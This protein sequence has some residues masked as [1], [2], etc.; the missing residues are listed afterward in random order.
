MS[1]ASFGPLPRPQPNPIPG[2]PALEAAIR[3]LEAITPTTPAD[4]T[5]ALQNTGAGGSG[6][7]G[8]SAVWQAAAALLITID[9]D[10]RYD[11]QRLF[12]RT[13][14]A[15]E[16]DLAKPLE[17]RRLVPV[18]FLVQHLGRPR[19]HP[20]NLWEQDQKGID[21]LLR[22]ALWRAI[23]ALEAAALLP[24]TGVYLSILAEQ[25]AQFERVY[26]HLKRRAGWFAAL[27]I[28][29]GELRLLRHRGSRAI[30]QL[31]FA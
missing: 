31:L 11:L 12:T 17:R 27:W 14:E 18:A 9:P 22:C 24:E 1:F 25:C 4:E 7:P 21:N 20:V 16:A 6:G 2:L 3:R 5:S 30:E 23:D 13:L 8:G 15:A 26:Q 29:Y 10:I 19:F 28:A